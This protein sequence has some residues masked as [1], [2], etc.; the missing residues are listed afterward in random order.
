MIFVRSTFLAVIA[1]TA[2]GVAVGASQPHETSGAASDASLP[3]TIP[4]A[5]DDLADPRAQVR[6]AA[7]SMLDRLAEE[8][9]DISPFMISEDARRLR[10]ETEPLLP[11]LIDALSSDDATVRTSATYALAA[12]GPKA[13]AALPILK[14]RWLAITANSSDD[15]YE[16]LMLALVRLVPVDEPV[17]PILQAGMRRLQDE[18]GAALALELTPE[19]LHSIGNGTFYLSCMLA[20]ANRTV[21]EVPHLIEM[22]ERPTPI[23]MRL[24]ALG[25]LENFGP[26]ARD[27]I[28]ALRRL[29]TDESEAVRICAGGALVVVENDRRR[30]KEIAASL[31]TSPEHEAAFLDGAHL[32]FEQ[33]DQMLASLRSVA[34]DVSSDDAILAEEAAYFIHHYVVGMNSS[35]GA[36]RR[37]YIDA[38]RQIGPPAR[39]AVPQLIVLARDADAFTREYAQAALRAIDPGTAERLACGDTCRRLAHPRRLFRRLRCRGA[40][41]PR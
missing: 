4:Q 33:Q 1:L 7:C 24:F 31:R 15:N 36:T 28:P 17:L 41:I 34:K 2:F 6:A 23:A 25:I 19:C 11:K 26:E 9:L 30:V 35:E 38:L 14:R 3:L 29:L 12:I 20:N 8:H 27:A 32:H 13:R 22:A 5:I 39:S 37:Q 18:C 21:Q 10:D 16:V 40:L